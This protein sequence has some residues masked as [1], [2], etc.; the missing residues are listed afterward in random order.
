MTIA[1]VGG[2]VVEVIWWRNRFEINNP[3]FVKIFLLFYAS[4]SADQENEDNNKYQT[5]SGYAKNDT[6]V[7]W[8][9]KKWWQGVLD[10]FIDGAPRHNPTTVVG[11]FGH[12][13]QRLKCCFSKSVKSYF[14]TWLCGVHSAPAVIQIQAR[15]CL[16]W[17]LI[18]SVF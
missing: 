3:L 6:E 11:K 5:R 7:I 15:S 4:F 12:Y 10:F 17:V 2:I 1:G 14:F 16:D 8:E 9:S 13:Y 18:V